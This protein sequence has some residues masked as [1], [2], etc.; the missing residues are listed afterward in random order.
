M[1]DDTVPIVIRIE[2]KPVEKGQKEQEK[3]QCKLVS[4][5]RPKTLSLPSDFDFNGLSGPFATD[6]VKSIG[7]LIFK[8]LCKNEAI[9]EAIAESNK[10]RPIYID[11][12]TVKAETISWETLWDKDFLALQRGWPI[13]RRAESDV[14]PQFTMDL[15]AP[16]L[17]ILAVISA[18]DYP[19][20]PEW[21]AL[22]K[23]AQGATA[24]G[25]PVEIRV[26]T[27][28]KDLFK[29]I[30]DGVKSGAVKSTSV[31]AVPNSE[32]SLDTLIGTFKPHVLHFFCHGEIDQGAW[33]IVRTGLKDQPFSI[34]IDKL[35]KLPS[36]RKVWLVVLNSCDS[37]VPIGDAP[38]M[39]YQLVARV[40]VPFA[41][42][43]MDPVD[44]HDAYEFS[45]AFYERL[46]YTLS[47]VF[48]AARPK[49]PITIGWADALHAAR[50]AL[51][52]KYGQASAQCNQ[53]TL[54]V[55]YMRARNDLVIAKDPTLAKEAD[56]PA[57]PVGSTTPDL[58]AI[59]ANMAAALLRNLSP[60]TSEAIK[61][62]LVAAILNADSDHP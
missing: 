52:H 44:V 10:A 30:D 7:S 26:V 6:P 34:A 48:K 2:R 38:S 54:P 4:P 16:P 8:E 25:L 33:L 35:V 23:A 53:W 19:G 39:A 31:K 51:D 1:S 15:F 41:I 14:P 61:Q 60:D 36:L 24:L 21:D 49:E 18:E 45:A 46:L 43:T 20:E 9:E 17:R 11:T 56:A 47:Q 59:R 28:D 42:G 3:F 5:P 27:G 12:E 32:T 57:P 13:V 29:K 40:G 55:L 62:A 58:V 50:E 22:Y 37:S